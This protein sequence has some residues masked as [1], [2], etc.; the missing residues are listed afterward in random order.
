MKNSKLLAN[1]SKS[2]IIFSALSLLSVSL[3][4]LADPQ[5]V[6][7][8][9]QT[10][11][12][13]TDAYSSIRGIYGG[14][15]LAIVISL[16]SLLRKNTTM[17]LGFLSLFWGAYAISRMI[18]MFADGPLGDFGHQWL[19][20]ESIFCMVALLLYRLR[21]AEAQRGRQSAGQLVGI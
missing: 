3:M 12:P 1:I 11:L 9:V 5:S 6:M 20:L 13:N 8:L 2:F 4:A 18:T 21:K 15:G 16:L 17:A 14:V 7:D 19:L 10:T